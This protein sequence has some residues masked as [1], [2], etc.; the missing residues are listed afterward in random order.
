MVFKAGL[1]ISNVPVARMPTLNSYWQRVKID[2]Y[3]PYIVKSSIWNN[4][5]TMEQYC[6]DNAAIF[7][8]YMLSISDEAF[9]L[10]V[11]INYA[12][13][14]MSEIAEEHCKV[15]PALPKGVS[16]LL[17]IQNGTYYCRMQIAC[18]TL[19]PPL[20]GTSIQNTIS[21]YVPSKGCVRMC[22]GT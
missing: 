5:A 2:T 20:M 9:L 13:T 18:A 19:Q 11:L 21:C 12:A 17:T 22:V 8:K 16:C 15:C 4:D 1:K 7:N 10:I 6:G 14:W 3:A